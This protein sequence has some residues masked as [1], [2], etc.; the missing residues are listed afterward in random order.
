MKSTKYNFEDLQV[1]QKSLD[2]VDMVYNTTDKFPAEEMYRLSSHYILAAISIPLNTDEGSGDTDAQ[3]N[4]YLQIS[5][6]SVKECVVC[7]SI[8]RR[9]K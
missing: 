2:F 7:S 5:G 9:R 8:A 1:Y 4:H 6:N 3:L